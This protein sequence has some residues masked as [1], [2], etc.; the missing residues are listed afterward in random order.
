MFYIKETN[1]NH[2]VIFSFIISF[3]D[4]STFFYFLKI[5]KLDV[6]LNINWSIKDVDI[7]ITIDIF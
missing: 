4:I 7:V 5:A 6:T 1:A 2:A 3:K